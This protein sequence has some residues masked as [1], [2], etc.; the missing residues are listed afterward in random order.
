MK[1]EPLGGRRHV[2]MTKRRAR[3]DWQ[4]LINGML[5]ERDQGAIKVF[6]VNGQSFLQRFF[7]NRFG[8]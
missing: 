3:V 6:P 7:V 2:E 1:V 5:D 4:G 8:F